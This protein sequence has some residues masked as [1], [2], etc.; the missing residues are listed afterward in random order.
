M[1]SPKMR[2]LCAVRSNGAGVLFHAGPGLSQHVFA[3]IDYLSE[4]V[5]VLAYRD[6]H[7]KI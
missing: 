6:S 2:D 1:L 4:R 7:F 5:V 3:Q